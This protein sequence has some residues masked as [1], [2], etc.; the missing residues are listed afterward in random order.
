[1]KAQISSGSIKLIAENE[2]DCLILR[3]EHE[4]K[5]IYQNIYP[6]TKASS[7][8]VKGTIMLILHE[9]KEDEDK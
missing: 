4:D 7:K 2:T 1:M 8:Y 9:V 6:P 5:K 3:N